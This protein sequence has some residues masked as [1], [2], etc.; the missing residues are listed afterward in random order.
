MKRFIALILTLVCMLGLVSCSAKTKT[1][2][3]TGA[4]KLTVMSGATGESV[5]IT[6][7]DDIKYITDNINAL[8]YSK[9]EKIDSSG[10]RYALQWI[11]KNGEIIEKLTLMG[12][13]YTIIYDGYYYKGM[14]ADYEIDLSV[15][16]SLFID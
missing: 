12:D 6:N 4:E 8:Q 11:D 5:D 10:W 15:L 1:F 16:D 13:S 7:A 9:G 3:I 14:E 2:E